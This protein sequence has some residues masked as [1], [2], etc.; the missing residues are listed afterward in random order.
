MVIHKRRV[1]TLILESMSG[2]QGFGLMET[3][4][5]QGEYDEFSK[6]VD[7]LEGFTDWK[8]RP[9]RKDS[10][11]GTRSTP[12]VYLMDGFE[13]IAGFALAVNLVTYFIGSMHLEIAKAANAHTNF[14]GTALLLSLLGGF[15]SDAYIN[16]FKA[17][18]LFASI[19]LVGYV[20]LTM[21]AHYAS[22]KP[23]PCNMLDP[24]SVCEKVGGR[25]AG[26]LFTGLY[27]IALGNGGIKGSLLPFGA[28]Q[29]DE[30]DPKERRSISTYFNMFFLCL[31]IG[32]TLAATVVVWVENEKGWDVGFGISGAAI[33]IAITCLL[34]G[35]ATY[36]I[37]IP[38]GSPLTRIVQVFTA[39]FH[40][41]RLS[42]PENPQNLY[43]MDDKEAD[44][45]T[46]KLVHTNQ[47]KF[48]DRAAISTQNSFGDEKNKGRSPWRLCS[49]SQVEET[50][51]LVRMVPV[52]ASTIVMS[53]CLAQLQTFSVAQGATMDR[54]MGKHFNIPAASLPII[55]VVFLLILTPIY[56]RFFV[57]FARKLTGHETGITHLQRIGVGLVLSALS[58][59]TAALVEARRKNVA[60]DNGMLDAIPLVM[61]PIP[62]SVFWLGFQY[63]LF[64]V[65]ELF[66]LVGLMEFFYSEAPVGMRSMATALS[67]TSMSLGYFLSTVLVDIVN[68]A[69]KDIT[70]SRGWL[71]GNNLNRNHLNLFYWLLAC[72]S[73][74]NFFNYLCWSRWYNYRPVVG[75]R[76]RIA[77]ETSIIHQRP[78]LK[79]NS[80]EP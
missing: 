10:H 36:R 55:P 71:R 32:A 57:P 73:V 42:T 37:R 80:S 63:F 38:G 49:V 72:L 58:M 68:A 33:F 16:R 51:I 77:D 69:T 66:T 44:I 22:L 65:A 43:E 23:R 14:M 15:V 24:T 70:A 29:F 2:S 11:G 56:D 74:L 7:E 59:G 28:D 35:F 78:D 30:R 67:W 21:Q 1:Y 34:A 6:E 75:E 18:L 45:S 12:F 53:T 13:Y 50:K 60:R 26:M 31:N 40:N 25:K 41:R 61:P 62:I 79:N 19:E 8:G 3:K 48:L 27:L 76:G 54:S 39:A 20:I 5:L 46:A 9:V 17:T 47:F 64:G 4:K 52:F